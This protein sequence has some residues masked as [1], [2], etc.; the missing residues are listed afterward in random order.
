[1]VAQAA[2]SFMTEQFL[3]GYEY[4]DSYKMYYNRETGYFYQP[5]GS[6]EKSAFARSTLR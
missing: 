5:V 6:R 4:I 1:M 2:S 3:Q